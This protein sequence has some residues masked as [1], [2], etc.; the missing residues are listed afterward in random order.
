MSDLHSKEEL[1]NCSDLNLDKTKSENN[2]L[3]NEL[4]E[5]AFQRVS[6]NLVASV[7]GSNTN[8]V[9][10]DG[11][12]WKRSD[13]SAFELNK[14]LKEEK[15][16]TDLSINT[17]YSRTG[18]VA[19][20]SYSDH[21]THSNAQQ[22]KSLKGIG[23]SSNSDQEREPLVKRCIYSLKQTHD[24]IA[25]L[26]AQQQKV[27]PKSI[28]CTEQSVSSRDSNSSQDIK[29]KKS[30]RRQ[31][32]KHSD[33]SS[34]TTST[35]ETP[36]SIEPEKRTCLTFPSK[37]TCN[38]GFDNAEGNLIIHVNDI[39]T[40]PKDSVQ[41]HNK[42][43]TSKRR[44]S[45]SDEQQLSYHFLVIELLGQ[46]TFAQV[47]KCRNLATNELVAFKIVKNKP[48]YT[49]QAEMEIHIFRAL[50]GM[51]DNSSRKQINPPV[52]S[53]NKSS[54]TDNMVTLLCYFTFRN[55]LCLVF[56]LLGWNL[57]EVL[58]KRQFRGLPIS[59]VRCFLKQA[60]EAVKDLCLKS[61]VH[62]DLKPENILLVDN[63]QDIIQ[64]IVNAGDVIVS[65]GERS[66]GTPNSPI[67]PHNSRNITPLSHDYS[68]TSTSPLISSSNHDQIYTS[69]PKIKLIDFGSACF[70]GQT[71]HTYIQSRFYRSP[72][73]LV[74]LSYD[75]SIDMW[76]LGCVAAELFLGLPILPGVH[77]HDQLCRIS[78]MIGP[79]PDW[80]VE[81]GS[82]SK[83]FYSRS[84]STS[85]HKTLN[86][87]SSSSSK[88]KSSWKLKS[89]HDYLKGLSN[90]E[91]SSKNLKFDNSSNTTNRYFKRKKL[92]DIVH[93][94]G[95]YC[96]N[97]EEDK[98][99]LKLFVHFLKGI[100]DPDP[101]TRLT[102]H[103]ALS[104]PFITG[105]VALCE[106]G[107][108]EII[109]SA[110]WDPTICRRKLLN[111]Q[112][113]REKQ[114]RRNAGT[115]HQQKPIGASQLSV[116]TV[117]ASND[118]P[119]SPINKKVLTR[120]KPVSP[121][122]SS[123]SRV[124]AMT[125]AMSLSQGFPAQVAS[126]P[127]SNCAK[128]SSPP[129]TL[130]GPNNRRVMRNLQNNAAGPKLRQPL[131][132]SG[133]QLNIIQPL[134]PNIHP[135][136]SSSVNLSSAA[137]H[138]PNGSNQNNSWAESH[139]SPAT[140]AAYMLSP[141]AG[142]YHHHA[143]SYAGVPLPQS[144]S[145]AYC[146]ST[147]NLPMEAELAY[148]LQRPGVLPSMSYDNSTLSNT[149]SNVARR[150]NTISSTND[151]KNVPS[152]TRSLLAQQLA[153]HTSTEAIPSSSDIS[154]IRHQHQYQQQQQLNAQRYSNLAV[155]SSSFHGSYH[156]QNPVMYSNFAP[157]SVGALIGT[158]AG[159]H[160]N[161]NYIPISNGTPV[162]Y[163][164]AATSAVDS[165]SNLDI[166]PGAYYTNIPGLVTNPQYLNA[167]SNASNYQA[168]LNA[169][170]N[171][172][173]LYLQQQQQQQQQMHIGLAPP[174]YLSSVGAGSSNPLHHQHSVPSNSAIN[175]TCYS[176]ANNNKNN[177]LSSGSNNNPA[178]P[179]N[180]MSSM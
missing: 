48:A 132:H 21:G 167:Q 112:K 33:R 180:G 3:S 160:P 153:E 4:M 72:E 150:H 155:Q 5:D 59:V 149:P 145:G 115:Q 30:K 159:L 110:P 121:E 79:L 12:T 106:V 177:T 127:T 135:T 131:G 23:V 122:F 138:P 107:T 42:S 84:T 116:S 82:K 49:R 19:K 66:S 50:S 8:R 123:T 32:K 92:A 126:L 20:S 29:G 162:I 114:L 86:Q 57:Y 15:N 118:Q 152:N 85:A 16:A 98:K 104:H 96:T 111:V 169:Q 87:K 166:P 144:F 73:V 18:K 158:T 105:N 113:N 156:Q 168:L 24:R 65:P 51:T 147:Q 81:Q 39:I 164:G 141:V 154:S 165:V 93:L 90:E 67:S 54:C 53:H 14:K 46:G 37:P 178:P 11:A 101:W 175:Q 47:F 124:T 103:Q 172:Q 63:D 97:D 43:Y 117:A 83:K 58:K 146:T 1:Y 151:D 136:S 9:R 109:W 139:L 7:W 36:D 94:H 80:M 173:L 100:L 56:E 75:S 62:C 31:Q 28:A 88:S 64:N 71:E 174:V 78:E 34:H 61:I 128:P 91:K 142:T 133:G 60:L 134:T 102:A 55:H 125:D 171:N 119:T 70:E 38:H 40:I 179:Y 44:P 95:Q 120:G 6:A 76:S 157:S 148:A 68:C 140:T 137:Y 69:S 22:K 25:Q 41:F 52:P 89:Y 10:K 108:Q 13:N 77:E 27:T 163:P 170:Y 130:G 74:G 99:F 2:G 17:S 45:S 26:Q 143:L 161:E 35:H 176:I 129:L